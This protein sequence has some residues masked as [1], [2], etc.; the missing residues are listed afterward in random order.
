MEWAK[1]LARKLAGRE[2]VLKTPYAKPGKLPRRVS[3]EITTRCNL[4]CVMC[5]HG[6]PS[7]IS[8]WLA[9]RDAPDAMVKQILEHIDELEMLHPTGTGEPLLSQGFWDIAERLRGRK[10]PQLIFNTNCTLL[11]Q[12][13]VEKLA[14]LPLARVNLSLDAATP[15]TYKKIR[16]ASFDKVTRG[17]SRLVE[18][19]EKVAPQKK[20][21][22]AMSMVLMRE[23]I[24]EAPRFV[25]LASQLGVPNVY[26]EHLLWQDVGAAQG[27]N[28]VR[29]G[30]VFNYQR[31]MLGDTPEYADSFVIGALDVADRLNIQVD[32]RGIFLVPGNN[33]HDERPCRQQT[34][35]VAQ[36][37]G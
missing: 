19:I 26:F 33:R 25:E 7:E 22:L 37:F 1:K 17:I 6:A 36:M 2:P 34:K 30:F 31:Q 21:T 12:E 20:I 8:N 14:D 24:E 15:E 16:G 11:T 18:R 23:N 13:N 3:I 10:S 27:W 4:A 28:A 9:K 35:F 5:A 29:D 32:G